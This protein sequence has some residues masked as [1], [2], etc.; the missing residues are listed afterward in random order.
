MISF[1]L[2]YHR[3]C[4]DQGVPRKRL[5]FIRQETVDFKFSTDRRAGR[6]EHP[7]ASVKPVKSKQKSTISRL[8]NSSL[9]PVPNSS[10]PSI[11]KLATTK[12][13]TRSVL[14]SP[15]KQTNSPAPSKLASPASSAR[16]PTTLKTIR[17]I[18][19]HHF[20]L[21]ISA[22]IEAQQIEKI[23]K[24]ASSSKLRKTVGSSTL[25]NFNRENSTGRTEA[26]KSAIDESNQGPLK[27]KSIFAQSSRIHKRSQSDLTQQVSIDD[28][29]K[30]FGPQVTSFVKTRGAKFVIKS[31]VKP[32]KTGYALFDRQ[33]S[34]AFLTFGNAI[35][36]TIANHSKM[37]KAENP[38]RIPSNL[39]KKE[40]DIK[41]LVGKQALV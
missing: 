4:Q 16:K 35:K 30:V 36:S 28:I 5:A 2:Q 34:R 27:N 24:T 19:D 26:Q 25:L 31:E 17:S 22:S 39:V 3:Y 29:Q 8:S 37:H 33:A 32:H 6:A 10:R 40:Y 9:P 14:N 7:Y 1:F 20:E 11:S 23:E 38:F 18:P 15:K 13:M 12:L 21:P 41:A